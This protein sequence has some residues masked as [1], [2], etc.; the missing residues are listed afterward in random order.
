MKSDDFPEG[1]KYSCVL[2]ENGERV[3]GY[4]NERGKGHH[5]HFQGKEVRIDFKDFENLLWGFWD[6][7]EKLIGGKNE[8]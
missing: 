7:V 3:L 2:I 5:K 8:K 6:E 4:D 1:I